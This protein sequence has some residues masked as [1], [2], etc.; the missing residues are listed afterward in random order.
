M[1]R[2]HNINEIPFYENLI[3]YAP[4]SE[5]DLK[6][7]VSGNSFVPKTGASVTYDSTKD[8]YLFNKQNASCIVC[9]GLNLNIDFSQQSFSNARFT[10]FFECQFSRIYIGTGNASMVSLGTDYAERLPNTSYSNFTNTRR[11]SSY[12]LAFDEQYKIAIVMDRGACKLYV[13]GTLTDYPDAGP[14]D[15]YDSYDFRKANNGVFVN[16]GNWSGN[17]G[18]GYYKDIRIYNRALTAEEVAQL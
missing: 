12:N 3:F 16:G 14:Y 8:M 11:L 18:G 15:W 6:D 5:G 17:D 7:H 13:N 9:N 2:E 1:K 4:L 10:I